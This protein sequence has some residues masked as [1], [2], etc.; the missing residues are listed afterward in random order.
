VAD[1][2]VLEE[3]EDLEA[4]FGFTALVGVAEFDGFAGE[5][6]VF[7]AVLLEVGE[8]GIGHDAFF[9]GEVDEDVFDELVE[10]GAESVVGAAGGEGG[11][12]LGDHADEFLM[13]SIDHAL[14]E[15]QAGGPGEGWS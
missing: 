10:D 15:R 3:E 2:P 13:L 11:L 8:A 9:V 12:E 4:D 7:G 6:V 1:E 5:G 14:I